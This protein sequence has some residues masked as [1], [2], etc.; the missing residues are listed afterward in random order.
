MS[1]FTIPVI[2]L[3]DYRSEDPN[4]RQRFIEQVGDSLTKVGFFALTSHGINQDLI[5]KSYRQSQALFD[6]DE[7]VK[8]DYE[9]ASLKGQRGYTSFGREHAKDSDAPDLK[10][11][12]H[13]GQEL[14]ETNPL[15]KVYPENIWPKELPGFK[16]T[17]LEIYQRLEQCALTVLDACARYIDEAPNTFSNMAI[18]GN[19]ILRLIHYPPIPEDAHPS[20]VRAAAHEDINL[21]TLLIDA[22]SSGLEILDRQG[23]W[24]P[25]VTPPDSIIIDAGDMLQNVSNGFFKSTTH[26][27]VNPDDSRSRRFSMPF[28][29]H[30][31]SDVDLTPLASCIAKTGGTRTYA[32]IS[33]GEYL[34]QRLAEIGLA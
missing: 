25:V 21:I 8:R 11:F 13:V 22:T 3:L 1:T 16:D 24:L 14:K 19:S 7:S 15:A 31:R 17:M 34:N 18:D 23:R 10:E 29:V 33:A 5:Q 26:R 4:C 28:F 6:L 20:S 2:D 27:V 9:I 12:W 32:E 30:A